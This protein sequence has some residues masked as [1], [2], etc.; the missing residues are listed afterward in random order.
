MPM[1]LVRSTELARFIKS[2]TLLTSSMA[3]DLPRETDR[4]GNS[5]AEQ[6]L[7]LEFG[8]ADAAVHH[9]VENRFDPLRVAQS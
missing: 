4:D 2:T 9:H 8:Y 7:A 5:W 3:N 1:V 6:L